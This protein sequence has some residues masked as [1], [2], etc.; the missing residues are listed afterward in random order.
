[1]KIAI[2]GAGIAG[3]TL[4]RALAT[5][6]NTVHVF[7]KSRGLGGRLATRRCSWGQLDLG[8]QYF[9]ARSNSFQAVT[10]EWL[11]A[12]VVQPWA[13]QPYV[14]GAQGL[15]HSPDAQ[16]RYVGVPAMNSVSHYMA[17]GVEVKR[18]HRIAT[19]QRDRQHWTL[20]CD[21]GEKYPGYDWVVSTLPVE[22]AVPLLA[23]CSDIVATLPKAM[24]RPCWAVGLATRGQVAA[25]NQGIFGDEQV[26]WVS[27]Q[28]AKPGREAG[29]DHEDSWMLHFAPQWSAENA[30]T[31]PSVVVETAA[32]WLAATL[33]TPLEV[34][35]HVAHYWRY[36]SVDPR[37]STTGPACHVDA[38][39]QL[40]VIGAWCC[41][42][43]V[44]GGHLSAMA[45]LE[46]CFF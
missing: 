19:L 3:L 23:D 43:R 5:P 10:R 25:D 33:D 30:D 42:G 32:S 39:Q 34:V 1:M 9:T 15:Q 18:N 14:I 37:G 21:T 26:A 41:G 29:K 7:E 36:A 4:A 31:T 22:Q 24:H 13:M 35:H 6:G 2:I 20:E 27:R 40:A 17:E 8:A 12:G 11:D 38:S 16:V 46:D 44:E 45:L 28:S